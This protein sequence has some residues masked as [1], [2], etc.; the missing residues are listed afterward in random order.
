MAKELGEIGK[1][2]LVST[3]V[4]RI[5]ITKHNQSASEGDGDVVLP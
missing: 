3:N 2:F 4:S 5:I 1:A